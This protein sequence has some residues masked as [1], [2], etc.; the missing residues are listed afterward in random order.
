MRKISYCFLL[1]LLGVVLYRCN[2]DQ[3]S[4]PPQ[5]SF[6]V[7][8]TSGLVGNTQF[9]FVVNHVDADAISLFPYGTEDATK[10]G[11]LLQASD[12]ISGKATIVFT[13]AF[14]GA[15]NA[16]VVANK[17]S[18]DGKTI[19]NVRS[20]TQ[21]IT[22]TNDQS[23]MT[24]FTVTDNTTDSKNPI[25]FT[26]NFSSNN[27]TV[28]LPY[29]NRNSLTKLVAA[30]TVSPFAVV[31]VGGTTQVSG[32][33]VNDFTSPVTYTVKSNDGATTSNYIVTVGVTPAETDNTL[34]SASGKNISKSAKDKA[35]PGVVDNAAKTIVIYD[36]IGTTKF[37]SIRVAYETTGKFATASLQQDSL[38]NL[39]NPGTMVI[40]AQN[41]TTATYKI[42][43]AAAPKLQLAFNALVPAVTAVTT[44]FGIT[45]DVLNGPGSPL[46]TYISSIATTST[47]TTAAGVT[48]TGI[49]ANGILFVS[50]DPV[51]YSSNA[52]FVL[53]VVDSNL[54]ITYK[55][56]YTASVNVIK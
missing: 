10:G 22:L 32:T 2:S 37:D 54:G 28:T 7:D 18:A 15:F 50:G 31:T 34:K 17:H 9:T 27:V 19:K 39:T 41:N 45:A 48:V 3:V 20:A 29:A 40:T 23:A 25:A 56:T 38:L 42:Y 26:G 12:F 14:V 47:V 51:D 49:T 1:G 11:I 21:S 55:V 53:T 33:T 44:N 6:T 16:V 46:P 8:K 5:P 24:A 52:E 13:Y 4:A 43:A 35:L 30:F 36:T